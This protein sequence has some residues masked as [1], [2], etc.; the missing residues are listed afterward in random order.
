MEKGWIQ[1]FMTGQD[2]KAQMAKDLL[3]EN[4]I[5]ALILNHKDSTFTTFGDIEVYVREE[6]EEKAL[7]IIKNLKSGEN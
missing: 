2:F 6:V 3:E 5:E 4:G 7:D 1:I